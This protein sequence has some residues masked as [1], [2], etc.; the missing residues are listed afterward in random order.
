MRVQGAEMNQ[1]CGSVHGMVTYEGIPDSGKYELHGQEMER[2][3]GLLEGS[4][5][6]ALAAGP[7]TNSQQGPAWAPS[8]G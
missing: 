7:Y 5:G 6:R 2:E 1:K 4:C 8:R 3:V